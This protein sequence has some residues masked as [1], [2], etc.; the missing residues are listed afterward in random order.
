MILLICEIYIKQVNIK[1]VN[2]TRKKQTHIY[3]EQTSGYQWA[4]ERREG[5]FRSRVLRGTKYY[6]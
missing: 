4:E 1:L 6:I 3:R 5:Q 2:I